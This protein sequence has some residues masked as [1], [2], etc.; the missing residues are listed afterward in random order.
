MSQLRATWGMVAPP[1]DMTPMNCIIS[2]SPRA[3]EP[4][5]NILRGTIAAAKGTATQLRVST[6]HYTQQQLLVSTICQLAACCP[7]QVQHDALPQELPREVTVLMPAMLHIVHDMHE[8]EHTCC[9]FWSVP[10]RLRAVSRPCSRGEC[11]MML[12]PRSAHF[13]TVPSRSG[14]RSRM[15]YLTCITRAALLSPATIGKDLA[16]A[17]A[18]ALVAASPLRGNQLAVPNYRAACSRRLF[19]K[20]KHGQVNCECLQ[21]R[22]AVDVRA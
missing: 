10:F 22:T 7:V 3:C 6:L 8:S 4:G 13:A 2:S 18:A 17:P 5:E 14:P 9:A 15:L 20:S 11:A 21:P 19:T 12:T 1:C 16:A